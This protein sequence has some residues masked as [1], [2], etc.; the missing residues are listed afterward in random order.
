[1][2]GRIQ[3]RCAVCNKTH[4]FLQRATYDDAPDEGVTVHRDCLDKF[5]QQLMDEQWKLDME[6]AYREEEYR[7]DEEALLANLAFRRRLSR[8][9]ST[10]AWNE[11]S[12]GVAIIGERDFAYMFGAKPDTRNFDKNDGN[13]DIQLWL[14]RRNDEKK[15]GEIDVKTS[16]KPPRWLPVDIKIIQPHRIYVQMKLDSSKQKAVAVGWDWGREIKKHPIAYQWLGNSASVHLAPVGELRKMEDLKKA[17]QGR[18]RW[19]DMPGF[20]NHPPDGFPARY[21]NA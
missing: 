17:Y 12:H 9:P 3:G 5:Y 1:M 18:W 21:R 10:Q 4:G 11:D 20:P 2:A 16:T 8:L 13:I 14:K 19:N 7:L 6:R 15:W